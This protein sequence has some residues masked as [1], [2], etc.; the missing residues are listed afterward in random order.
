MEGARAAYQQ[1]IDSG[2]P[3]KAPTAE[4]NLGL[5]LEGQ[6]DVE[7]ARACLPA[8]HRLRTPRRGVKGQSQPGGLLR[9]K[10]MWRAPRAAYQ[11][12]I[13][14]GHPDQA[15]MAA[16]NAP[17]VQDQGDVEGA[18]AAYQQ[19]IDSGHPDQ[20]PGATASLALLL[21]GQGD[22]EGARACYQQA[23]DSGHPD[24]AP[25]ATVSLGMLLEGQGD[26]EGAE[27]VLPAG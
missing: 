3:D 2:H 9:A 11:Q 16:R 13:D 10:G 12:A 23:I 4:Y 20:A 17:V 14:S 21:E 7:G 19:A 6:G 8:G 22:V 1:V 25:L 15:P 26:V 27:S 24:A 5:L 18:R